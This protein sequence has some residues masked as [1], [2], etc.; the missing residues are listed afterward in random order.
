MTILFQER[1]YYPLTLLLT[2][3]QNLLQPSNLKFYLT[4][5]IQM[6]YPAQFKKTAINGRSIVIG[7][8]CVSLICFTEAYNDYYIN[9]TWLAA[10]HFPIVAAFLLL[11]L[12]IVLLG[13]EKGKAE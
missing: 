7:L 2:R 10:H 4:F 8:I 5:E 9:N 6:R 13:V 1:W 11:I 12:V 3:N